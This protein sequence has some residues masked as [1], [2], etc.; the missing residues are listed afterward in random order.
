MQQHMHLQSQP[1]MRS[2]GPVTPRIH[3]LHGHPPGHHSPVAVLTSAP[4]MHPAGH[5]PPHHPQSHQPM[6]PQRA[7][8]SKMQSHNIP[9]QS[10]ANAHY[11]HPHQHQS[12][13]ETRPSV[14]ES[15]QPLI[16]ECT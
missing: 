1:H 14:I 13:G 8:M 15:S 10:Q 7:P 2:L 5:H 3:P 4:N 12:N 9:S 11:T 6:S 16:I